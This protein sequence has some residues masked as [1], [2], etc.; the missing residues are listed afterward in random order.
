VLL[1][2]GEEEA[3]IDHFK[4]LMN[5]IVE[6]PMFVNAEML[7]AD[8]LSPTALIMHSVISQPGIS[9]IVSGSMGTMERCLDLG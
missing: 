8:L 2:L 4:D 1:K 5:S 7:E 9:D 3:T 6:T